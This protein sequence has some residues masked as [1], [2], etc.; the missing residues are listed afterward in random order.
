MPALDTF[1]ELSLVGLEINTVSWRGERLSVDYGSGFGDEAATGTESGLWGWELSAEVLTDDDS[2]NDL[3]DGVPSAQYYFDFFKSHTTG[4]T[5]I[6]RIEFRG[7]YYHASFVEPEWMGEMHTIDL[8]SMDGVA[9]K[10]RR[11]RGHAYDSDGAVL[12]PWAWIT[13]ENN[14]TTAG[15]AAA[16]GDAISSLFDSSNNGNDFGAAVGSLAPTLQTNEVN[17]YSVIRFDGTNDFILHSGGGAVTLYDLFMVIKITD[18]S[19]PDHGG[20][21]RDS[22]VADVLRGSNGTTK[23]HDL[24]LTNYE[25]RKD[26]TLLADNNQQAPMAEFA[27]IHLRF[28]DGV[29]FTV[30]VEIGLSIADVYGAFDLAEFRFYDTPVPSYAFPTVTEFLMEIYGIA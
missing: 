9:I 10:M 7:K 3:I 2:Y 17:G 13:A 27:V 1:E 26:G 22:D 19:F 25:Y 28:D 21:L 8:F 30:S 23:F 16:D 12:Q 18:A 11:V 5:S 29:D 24:T 20:V 14:E 15:V 6:F 4:T